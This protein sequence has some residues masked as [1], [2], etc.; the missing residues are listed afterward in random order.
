LIEA[1]LKTW[2][3][4]A[5]RREL[6]RL[7]AAILQSRTRQSLEDSIAMQTLLAITLQSARR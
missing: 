2:T 5:I 6:G 4:P 1:A 3:L 7:Q